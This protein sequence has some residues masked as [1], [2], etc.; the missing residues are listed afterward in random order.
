VRPYSRNEEIAE[1]RREVG[2]LQ[3]RI[4]QLEQ[5]NA[6]LEARE[7]R[8][9]QVI[10]H[11]YDMI[12]TVDL[13]G[14]VTFLNAA[15]E[16]ITGYTRE[17]LPGKGLADILAPENL[18][19]A[20]EMLSRKW[21]GE[22]SKH[23]EI[24]ILAKNGRK[25]DLEIDSS[26]IERAGT[27]VGVLAI[28]RNITARKLA[29]AALRQSAENFEFLFANHPLPMWVFDSDTRQFLE[30][31][32]AAVEKYGYSREEFLAMSAAAVRPANEAARLVAYHSDTEPGGHGTAANV[33]HLTKGGQ[34]I[35][36]EVY[37]RSLAFGGRAAILAVILD[38]SARKL[39]EEQLRQ[40]H[41]LEAVGR[42][43][44][45]VAHDFN[46]LLTVITGYSQLLL[47]RLSIGHPM[48]SG[49]EQIRLSA[50]RAAVLT[51]QLLAFSRRQS[52]QPGILDLNSIVAGMG[53]MLS[54]L[55]G[56]H[57]ELRTKLNPDL[58][59]VQ[60]DPSQIEQ[61]ILNLTLN[62]REAIAEEE[63]AITLETDNAELPP[64]AAAG[65]KPG[66]YA[67]LAVTDTGK[68]IDSKIR[69]LLF[70]PFFTTKDRA[71]GAGLGLSAVHGMVEQHG[72]FIRVESESGQG[73]RFEVYLPF[74]PDPGEMSAPDAAG[75][76]GQET[77]LVV[78]DESGVLRLIGETLRSYGYKVI[79]L[80]DSSEALEMA[81]REGPQIDLLL[82]D[83]VMPKVNGRSVAEA[84]KTHHPD[85]KVL[86]MSGYWEESSSGNN[87]TALG[88]SLLQK[89]FSGLVLARKVREV[90]DGGAG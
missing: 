80:D 90:L 61:I 12:W 70:D 18:E 41:K 64:E 5:A 2:R 24:Q 79:E 69:G 13:D 63:G 48:Q 76:H 45:G 49:L 52:L 67:R 44:G 81:G 32:Q 75:V 31:N 85:L 88:Y 47:N 29:Q 89:P 16:T 20:A 46:N 7:A 3:E 82:T 43:A 25:V 26:L 62:A 66:L 84:W 53:K 27:A 10:E 37:W 15:C 86:F 60:A 30:V 68:G 74:S 1:S 72:G 73:A 8:Y 35:D 11:A 23:Y 77:V 58:G 40:A 9:R 51:R 57:I 54:R 6:L 34:T 83:V 17:E 78:E 87:L 14:S 55:I 22:R 59:R 65:R 38:I 39:L 19:S 36:T 56:E 21:S 50:E 71:E 4:A 33:R 42:L 28:A